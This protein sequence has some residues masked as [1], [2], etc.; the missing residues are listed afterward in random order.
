MTAWNLAHLCD[1]QE[2]LV[3]FRV[4]LHSEMSIFISF[5][6]DKFGNPVGRGF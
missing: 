5:R 4:G 2:P 1:V 6:D 3:G